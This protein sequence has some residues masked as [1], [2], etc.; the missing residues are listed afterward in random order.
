MYKVLPNSSDKFRK[1]ILGR[2]GTANHH[3]T[4][5][6]KP[7]L[8]GENRDNISRLCT[9]HEGATAHFSIALCFHLHVTY[10]RK[11]IERRG[12]VALPPR[13]TDLNPLDFFFRGH[14]KSL[15]YETPMITMEDG[16]SSI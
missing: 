3:R 4:W 5:G 11:W 7:S 16:L 6:H 12:P 8:V 14:L 1:V 10:P 2:M 13:S 15:V 9:T